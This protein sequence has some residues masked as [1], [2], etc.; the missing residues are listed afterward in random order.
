MWPWLSHICPKVRGQSL[1]H[2]V[3]T[4]WSGRAAPVVAFELCIVSTYCHSAWEQWQTHNSRLRMDT[5]G[6]Q[7]G[8]QQGDVHKEDEEQVMPRLVGRGRYGERAMIDALGWMGTHQV[9]KPLEAGCTDSNT[10]SP[11]MNRT[12]RL[13]PSSMFK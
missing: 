5:A 7:R 12:L 3:P 2:V 6:L 13:D 4:T 10:C 8:Q 9:D 1:G 11:S